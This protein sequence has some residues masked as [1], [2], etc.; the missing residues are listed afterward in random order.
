MHK[1][2][3]TS[4]LADLRRA[5]T[6]E[7]RGVALAAV[8]SRTSMLDRADRDVAVD[9]LRV[10]RKAFS[11]AWIGAAAVE[12]IDGIDRVREA[13]LPSAAGVDQ[14]VLEAA[15]FT[16]AAEAA[17]WELLRAP[18]NMMRRSHIIDSVSPLDDSQLSVRLTGPHCLGPL[19]AEL[20]P[21]CAS[22]DERGGDLAGLPGLRAIASG[23]KI[24]LR[25]LGTGALVQILGVDSRDLDAAH[26][27]CLNAYDRAMSRTAFAWAT[28]PDSRTES[29]RAARRFS[30]RMPERSALI[31]HVLRRIRAFSSTLRLRTWTNGPCVKIEWTGH[32]GPVQLA[33]PL[34]H[35]LTGIPRLQLGFSARPEVVELRQPGAGRGSPY[36]CLLRDDD[37]PI[38]D[39]D[40]ASMR[41]AVAPTWAEWGDSQAGHQARRAVDT[42][43]SGSQATGEP[44]ALAALKASTGTFTLDSCNLAQRSL[45]ALLALHL[46]NAG[47]GA[48]QRFATTGV[49]VVGAYDIVVSAWLDNTVLIS[50]AAENV[51]GWLLPTRNGQ[52]LAGLRLLSNT[53]DRTHHLFHIPTGAH[54]TVMSETAARAGVLAVPESGR[55]SERSLSE[56]ELAAIRRWPTLSTDASTLLAAILVRISTRSPADLW[57]IGTW[58]ADPLGRPRGRETARCT[59]QRRLSAYGL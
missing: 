4:R 54:L 20:L 12:G 41:N 57:A 5:C 49:N 21:V 25:L 45:R 59:D 35:P 22:P 7:S 48:D 14:Q 8:R 47:P 39:R 24:E 44:R 26:A 34:I 51:V 3:F 19:L 9:I 46:L 32:V 29:E 13:I 23:S 31:S 6:G 56:A 36:L 50:N 42:L 27:F 18:G 15:V 40:L 53:S 11:P 30:Y 58:Y 28:H 37:L 10:G 55:S 38:D 33:K 2:T 1:D 43:S 52:G 16:A 17:E